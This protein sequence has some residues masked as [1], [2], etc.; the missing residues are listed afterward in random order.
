[1]L[2]FKDID[3]VLTSYCEL[4]CKGNNQILCGRAYLD[5]LLSWL[6]N[7]PAELTSRH[8]Y[9]QFNQ[10]SKSSSI[11][12]HV[13]LTPLLKIIWA[14]CGSDVLKT[15]LLKMLTSALSFSSPLLLGRIVAYLQNTNSP[16]ESNAIEGVVLVTL[17][18]A[19]SLS[20]ALL[21]TNYN[22]RSWLIKTK[23]T[24]SLSSALFARSISVPIFRWSQLG[25]SEAQV[26]NLIQIDVDQFSD[27]FKSIHDIWALPLQILITFVLLYLRIRL[28]FLAGVAVILLMLPINSVRRPSSISICS[29]TRQYSPRLLSTLPNRSASRLLRC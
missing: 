6:P 27:C 13:H 3:Y 16:T 2:L 28:A 25:I 23:L 26:N 7:L 15:G 20:A 8:S 22:V 9:F 21:N 19:C 29:N 17:L 10:F 1:M 4:I 12:S 14:L 18:A 11:K 24:G 5:K